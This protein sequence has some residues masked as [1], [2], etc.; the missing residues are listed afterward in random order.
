MKKLLLAVTTLVLVS[1]SSFS[2][3][4]SID[5]RYELYLGVKV[6]GNYSHVYDTKGEEF[7][8]DPKLGLALG[9]FVSIPIGNYLGVQSEVLF[10]QIRN[11][12]ILLL[13]YPNNCPFI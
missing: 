9:A 8:A 11:F 1:A 4:E 6:G 10:S 12:Y 5:R 13:P 7:D 3:N 2:Q